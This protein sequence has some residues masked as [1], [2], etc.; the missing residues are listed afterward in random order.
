MS[1]HHI[2]NAEQE[3]PCALRF[4]TKEQ[5]SSLTYA[6]LK[7]AIYS[8]PSSMPNDPNIKQVVRHACCMLD[9]YEARIRNDLL[10]G[11]DVPDADYVAYME[12]HCQ[13]CIVGSND[14]G[15]KCFPCRAGN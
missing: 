10:N 15:G 5:L 6:E 4:A 9:K 8:H 12:T 11:F 7:D 13:T 3:Y 2:T 14:R 1:Y